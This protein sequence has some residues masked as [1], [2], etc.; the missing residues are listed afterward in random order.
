M[1]YYVS[2]G[3][4]THEVTVDGQAIALDDESVDAHID[5]VGGS[6]VQLL[7]IGNAV[8]RI[9]VRRGEVRGQYTLSIDGHRLAVEALDERAHA[10]RALSRAGARPSGPAHLVAPMPGLIVRVNVKERDQVRAGQ[11]LVVIEAMKMENELRAGAA[12]VVRRVL[13]APGSA[14]EKGAVLLELE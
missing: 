14:V 9:V 8:H 7:T 2:V 11:G 12:G 10:I 1:K 3:D 6:P 5:H 4:V 13:I